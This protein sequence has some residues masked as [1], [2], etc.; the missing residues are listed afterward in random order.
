MA[1]KPPF[2]ITTHKS[3]YSKGTYKIVDSTG[4]WHPSGGLLKTP[5]RAKNFLKKVTKKFGG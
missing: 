2:R 5:T 1:Y 4:R 3:G